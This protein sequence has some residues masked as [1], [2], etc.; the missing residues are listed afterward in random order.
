MI[1]HLRCL[2][3]GFARCCSPRC[4]GAAARRATTIERVVSPGGIEAWLVREPSLPL[5]A[6]EFRLRRRR[7]RRTRPTSPASATWSR[8]CSTRAPASSTPRPS[9]SGSRTTPIELRFSRR[10]AT[11]SAARCA[12]LKD[13][14]DESFDLLRLALNRAALRRRRGRAHARPDAGRRCAA[15]PPIPN[16]IA[17]RDLVAHRVSRTIPTAVRPTAR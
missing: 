17:S 3:I 8:R 12:L 10:A 2:V 4:R 9:S 14:Q 16:D 7:R 15:K 6:L 11:I 5:V 13:R 1:R